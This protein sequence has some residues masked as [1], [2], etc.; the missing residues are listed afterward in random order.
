MS[1]VPAIQS[2]VWWPAR[3]VLGDMAG[4]YTS[5]PFVVPFSDGFGSAPVQLQRTVDDAIAQEAGFYP[6]S[7]SVISQLA[8][9]AFN[10]VHILFNQQAAV[11]HQATGVGNARRR[12]A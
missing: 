4:A 11:D 3:A 1:L 5:K 2:V 6:G 7:P 10:N 12:V 9:L 8:H